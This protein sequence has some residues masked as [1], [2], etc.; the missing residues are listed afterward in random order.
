MTYWSTGAGEATRIATLTSPRRPGPAHLLPGGRDRARVAGEHGHV[1]PPD[2]HAQLERVGADDPEHLAVAE[3]ALDRSTFRRQVAG[4][5]AAQAGARPE[6]HPQGLAQ[7]REH[8]LDRDPRSP[9]DHG[10]ATGAQERQGPPLGQR[11]RRAARP[12]GPVDDRRIDEQEV[13]LAGGRAVAVDRAHGAA[14]QQLG[15]LGRVPD[16]RRAAHDHR[17][18][19]VVRAQPQE[20]PQHVGHVAAEH[21]AVHVQL[22]DHDDPQLLEQ[23]EPLRVVGEDRRVEHVRVGDDDLPG[24]AD[25]RPDGRRRVAVVGGARDL[26]AGVAHELRQ[27]RDLVL[28]ERLGGEQEQ[29]PG[30]RVLGQRLE[31]RRHVAQ[32]LARCRGRDHDDVLA[33]VDRLDRVG[34]VDVRPLDAALG[35][36]RRGGAGR[37]TPA[38]RRTG[39]RRPAGP[40][41]G[42]RRARA[43]A[44][45]AAAPGRRWRARGRRCACPSPASIWNG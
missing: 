23:L 41:D 13:L 14:D 37:A 31:H 17:V 40:R 4:P 36:A 20:A 16:G 12:G 38:T 3:A 32:R 27:L 44:R 33:G 45:R 34:L 5:V 43:T 15:E 28:P 9:E 42:R 30:R 29:R 18:A 19:A 35:A 2:V 21:A 11:Q 8:D 7:V 6:V 1:E 22:V 10:L 39:P 24:L 26:E 25:R